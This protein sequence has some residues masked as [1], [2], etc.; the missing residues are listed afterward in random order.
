[1]ME[2]HDRLVEY[3]HDSRVSIYDRMF[4]LVSLITIL[5]TMFATIIMA[6]MG[7]V[8]TGAVVFLLEC[9]MLAI[10]LIGYAKNILPIVAVVISSLLAL[11]SMPYAVI[12]D[13]LSQLGI[14]LGYMFCTV[15][16]TLVIPG[17][18]KKII[19]TL[20]AVAGIGAIA[21]KY[22]MK[23]SAGETPDLSGYI[24]DF[25]TVAIFCIISALIIGF[26]I[27]L[28]LVE[29]MNSEK[30]RKEIEKLHD[31]Q[32][33][34]FSSMSHEIRTPIN[35]IIG[36]NE[37]ILR[38]NASEE[39]N[40][41]AANIQNASKMLLHLINDILDMSKFESGEMTVTNV[42]YHTGDMLSDVVGM[43]WIRAK[44]KNLD[45]KIDVSPELPQE[46]LGDEV[47]IKQI[48][49]NVLTN[50][51]KYTREGSV[52]LQIQC[53]KKDDGYAN[54]IYSI[55]DTGMGIKKESIPYLF[56]AF[57]RVDEDKNRY[58][59]GTGLGLS[60][61]KRFVDLMGGKITVN[62]VYTKG[63]TF[64]IEIP[65]KI[66][67]DTELGD[68]RVNQ[69]RG[70]EGTAYV[71]SFEAP[72]ARVLVVDD[73]AANL[74]VVEKLLRATKVQ[75]DAVSSG[76]E[77]LQKT[78]DNTYDVILMDHMMPEMDGIECLHKIRKQK[79]GLSCDARIVALTANA[80]SDTELLYAK[81]GFDGYLVKPVTGKDLEAEVYRL[82]PKDLVVVTGTDE[83]IAQESM[84]W[85]KDHQKKDAIRITTE[86]VADVPLELQEKYGIRVIKHM[87]KTE[88]GIFRDGTEIETRGLLGY[89]ENEDA[90]VETMAP[91]EAE[92][93]VFFSDQLVK[94][95]N[96]I[97]L[98][99]SS[100]VEHSGCIAAEEAATEFDN[101]F[102]VDTGHLSSGQGLMA[103]EAARLAENGMST[104]EILK[105]MNKM[106]SHV[107]TS[108]VVDSMD[109]LARAGQIGNSAARACKAFMI[110]PIITLKK[111]KMG[112]GRIFLGTRERAWERYVATAFRVPG[113]IDRRMLFITYVG[114]TQKELEK[115]NEMV[116]R[117]IEF[118][119]VYFQ[120][121]SPAIAVNC[122]PGT[123]GL[124]FYTDYND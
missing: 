121:A 117:R 108:F 83:M 14:A 48:L 49:I 98:S 57:K 45:F 56:T 96:V 122:G 69:K 105:C 68:I 85:I 23:Y 19:L 3:L 26:Q 93:E 70:I 119:K 123:F 99:I 63:S 43:L 35:T 115:I 52:K 65:Q 46:L 102:V 59:E 97:H 124:L 15:Y 118:D 87:V 66:V 36:L 73:T 5:G 71:T 17:K 94:A 6:V 55:S 54:V 18:A 61:V 90:R 29:T 33:R 84:A 16:I 67:N 27:H 80:G 37:M 91:D 41:N 89:M 8:V 114:M 9:I 104:E 75:L 62:S 4:M 7:S 82:L 72:K 88:D 109:Y 81:E 101:V 22:C 103:I 111:G 74:L 42:P 39:I 38:E 58:I 79:G 112:V 51:I 64:I 95:N 92:H 120:K 1:M 113:K 44:E 100:K 47:R 28:F 78:F 110:H 40:E 13:Q 2:W 60:I 50:A 21:F 30:Q 12:S 34:F 116:S 10:I 106:K 31:S 20:M 11:V 77:A 24:M 53:E 25:V 32:N 76:K 107:Y 86:S